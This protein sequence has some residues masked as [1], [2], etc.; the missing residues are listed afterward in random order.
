MVVC[1]RGVRVC[2]LYD[3]QSSHTLSLSL[4]SDRLIVPLHIM[5]SSHHGTLDTETHA[6]RDLTPGI[7]V[8]N[9]ISCYYTSSNQTVIIALESLPTKRGRG[10]AKTSCS[11]VFK[12]TLEEQTAAT[13][14]YHMHCLQQAHQDEKQERR[15]HREAKCHPNAPDLCSYSQA[16]R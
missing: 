2:C 6:L 4:V 13:A 14:V 7:N 11:Y 1:E 5:G 3:V 8:L 12:D 15:A 10:A 16:L 9:Y